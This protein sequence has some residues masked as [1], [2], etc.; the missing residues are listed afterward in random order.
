[1]GKKTNRTADK[2]SVKAEKVEQSGK[3]SKRQAECLA[4]KQERIRAIRSMKRA[5]A[6]ARAKSGKYLSYFINT[7]VSLYENKIS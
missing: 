7:S 4:A 1:M 3:K 5:R 6:D 2:Q